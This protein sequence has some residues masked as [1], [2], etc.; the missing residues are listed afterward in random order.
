MGR[1]VCYRIIG[2]LLICAAVT[3]LNANP[4][5]AN[6]MQ[7]FSTL[8]WYQLE[9][10]RLQ[11]LHRM[12]MTEMQ[13]RMSDLETR[14]N[15]LYDELGASQEALASARATIQMQTSVIRRFVRED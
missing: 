13:K 10:Y 11:L 6:N 2:L 12:E 5:L 7:F 1:N 8:H 14:Y 4:D 15:E 3:R 9:N